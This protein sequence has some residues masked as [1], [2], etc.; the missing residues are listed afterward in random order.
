MPHSRLCS[1]GRDCNSN[2]VADDSCPQRGNGIDVPEFQKLHPFTDRLARN[3]SESDK[4][5]Q[6]SLIRCQLATASPALGGS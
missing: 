2:F 6:T 4:S 5:T 3:F 1:A